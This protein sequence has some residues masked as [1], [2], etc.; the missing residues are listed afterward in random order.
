LKSSSHQ[1]SQGNQLA[2]ELLLNDDI[3]YA[4]A[5]RLGLPTDQIVGANNLPSVFT[6]GT[7][8]A[9]SFSQHQH[10]HQSSVSFGHDVKQTDGSLRAPRFDAPD[11][12]VHNVEDTQFDSDDDL[13]SDDEDQVG[14]IEGDGIAEGALRLP[15][16]HKEN[17]AMLDEARRLENTMGVDMGDKDKAKGAQVAGAK[18]VLVHVPYMNFADNKDLPLVGQAHEDNKTVMAWRKLPRPDIPD[19]FFDKCTKTSTMGAEGSDIS[20]QPNNPVFLNPLSPVDACKYIPEVFTV[21]VE[22]IFIP[23]AKADMDRVLGCIER[24]IRKEEELSRNLPTDDLLLFGKAKDTTTVDEFVAKQYRNDKA[25]LKDPKQEAIEKAILAAKTSSISEMEDAL[26]EDIGI[27]IID[28]FGNSLLVLAAQQGSKRMCKYLL[29]RGAT[30]N[31]QNLQ[32]NTAMH[33]AHAYKNEDLASYLKL[34]GADD[35]IL[36]AQQL[37]C[38]EGLSQDALEFL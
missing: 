31:W 17:K 18:G 29:R 24:N 26:E 6:A 37:T 32:G 14:N 8:T 9:T 7:G 11:P 19:K 25:S 35:S 3:V 2:E 27:D 5:R 22:S 15:E 36:N 38:Y 12:V 21:D 16:S 30:I 34:R 10:Q 28:Q 23:D 4:L 20:N 13:W 1:S 33:Y